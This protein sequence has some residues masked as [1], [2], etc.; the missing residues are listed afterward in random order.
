VW[1]CGHSF[2]IVDVD[3]FLDSWS[4]VLILHAFVLLNIILSSRETT[5]S[6][7]AQEKLCECPMYFI[8]AF[9]TEK[10]HIL[11]HVHLSWSYYIQIP[12]HG[13]FLLHGHQPN[14][15]SYKAEWTQ[16]ESEYW[17]GRFILIPYPFQLFMFIIIIIW[18]WDMGVL[19]NFWRIFLTCTFNTI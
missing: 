11:M 16:K 15:L 10:L 7:T 13:M 18:N 14:A 5:S 8:Q 6:Q 17:K 9:K 2:S 19:G 3:I 12:V 4:C 1:N